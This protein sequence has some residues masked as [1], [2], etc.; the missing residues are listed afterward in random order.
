[1]ANPSRVMTFGFEAKRSKLIPTRRKWRGSCSECDHKTKW[2]LGQRGA[3]VN[4]WDHVVHEHIAEADPATPVPS[5]MV[6]IDL[7]RD[8][9]EAEFEDL[10]RRHEAEVLEIF[11]VP[12]PLREAWQKIDED[13]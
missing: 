9:T 11:D 7:D 8:L 6:E 4:I 12:K 3:K 2:S 13:G 1:M 10:K 5:C